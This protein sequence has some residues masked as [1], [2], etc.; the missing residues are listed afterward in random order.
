MTS[1]A[2]TRLVKA[3]ALNVGFDLAGVTSAGRVRHADYYRE[4]LARG[5]A[6]SMAYLRRN[7]PL[8]LEPAR[9]LPGAR[10][11]ICLGLSHHHPE[12]TPALSPSAVPDADRA[13]AGP[14]DGSPPA[15]RLAQYARGRDY[16]VVMRQMLAQ[17]VALLRQRIDEPF[18]ARVF[19]DT[20]PLLERDLASAAGLGWIGKNTCLLNRQL[21]SYVFL[22]EL[23]CTLT[24]EPDEPSP[25]QCGS[26]R[27]CLEACPTGALR[28][29]H[30][31]DAT[32]CI[33]YFTIEHRGPVPAEFHR[34]IGEWVFG[35]D[36][37]Q[38]VCPYNATAPAATLAEVAEDRLPARLNLFHLL[39]LRSGEY[40]RLTRDSA[41]RRATRRMWRRNAA[42]AAGNSAATDAA[43][44]QALATAARDEEPALQQAAQGALDRLTE[45]PPTT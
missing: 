15:G 38:E 36:I 45:R 39:G 42:I 41:T 6:G 22:A 23:V 34:Q 10:S 21:G 7:V 32:R 31:L 8:R 25:D 12:H 40:R 33:S 37:C 16:H 44:R 3:L 27:R 19:V 28:A 11:I 4:W 26:C 29:P 2:K 30:Q 20:G 17:Y 14:R 1:L 13:G 35:C 9:L 24:L 5:Y 18:E 43:I